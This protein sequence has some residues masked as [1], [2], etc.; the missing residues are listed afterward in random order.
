MPSSHGGTCL[1]PGQALNFLL[2]RTQ[3]TTDAATIV[4]TVAHFS[5]TFLLPYYR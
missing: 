5:F 4:V 1:H 3:S 2:S